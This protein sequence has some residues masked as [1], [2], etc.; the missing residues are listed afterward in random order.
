MSF[1]PSAM[2]FRLWY[3]LYTTQEHKTFWVTG[4]QVSCVHH[5]KVPMSGTCGIRVNST[6]DDLLQRY[7]FEYEDCD[8]KHFAMCQMTI[9]WNQHTPSTSSHSCTFVTQIWRIKYPRWATCPL[10]VWLILDISITLPPPP[11][12]SKW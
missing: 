1:Y 2:S 3:G 8:N 4:R 11:S 9:D 6:S 7:S 10:K 12:F 5:D